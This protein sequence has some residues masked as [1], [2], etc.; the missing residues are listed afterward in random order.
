VADF[1]DFAATFLGVWSILSPC[2]K[3]FFL[4]VHVP[5]LGE[6]MEEDGREIF[7]SILEKPMYN[8]VFRNF[9]EVEE[10]LH[11]FYAMML[12]GVYTLSSLSFLRVVEMP[13]MTCT[14]A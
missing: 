12:V 13:S 14:N 4:V 1:S 2:L 3:P 9:M 6:I 5:I 8:G 7:S 11:L 10:K